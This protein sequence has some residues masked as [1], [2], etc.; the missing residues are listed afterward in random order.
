MR[1]EV[2]VVYIVNGVEYSDV[3]DTMAVIQVA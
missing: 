2:I 3:S 1:D